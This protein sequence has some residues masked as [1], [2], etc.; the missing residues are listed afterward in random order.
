MLKIYGTGQC[1]DC[2]KCKEELDAAGVE[3]LYLDIMDKMLFLKQF[4]RLREDP[5]FEQIRKAGYIGIPCIVREDG[6]ITFDWKEF[7]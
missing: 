1:P 6:S 7:M 3:Y 5:A 4:L 2:V